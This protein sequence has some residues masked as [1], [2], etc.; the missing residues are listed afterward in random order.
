MRSV[1]Y[2]Q[3]WDYLQGGMSLDDLE[4][5][6]IIATRQLAKRQFTWLR[7]WDG[8]H[9]LDSLAHDN[10]PLALKYLQANSILD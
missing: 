8:L 6:G 3:V 7:G 4:Q 5:R 1:G 2:R 10:L 9:W